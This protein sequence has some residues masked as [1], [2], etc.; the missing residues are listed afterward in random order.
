[1]ARKRRKRNRPPSPNKGLAPANFPEL[2]RRFY[3]TDPHDYFSRRLMGLML[4]LGNTPEFQA[5]IKDEF[6]A[7]DVGVLWRSD[8][9]DEEAEKSR[10]RY[11]TAESEVLLHHISETLLRLYLVH[12]ARSP[13]PWLDIARERDFKKLKGD[14]ADLRDRLQD[15][16][17]RENIEYVFYGGANREAFNPVPEE[18]RWQASLRNIG[19]FLD[20]YAEQ[21]LDS[22]PYNAAKHGMAVV[23]GHSGIELGVNNDPDGP[24]LSKSGP[25]IEYLAIRGDKS[26]PRWAQETKWIDLAASIRLIGMA[27]D[28]LDVLWT[29]GSAHRGGD[30]PEK[31]RLFDYP[32]Y[33][34]MMARSLPE[35]DPATA[36]LAELIT[37]DR[38]SM[39]L[40]Y[41]EE[42]E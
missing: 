8:L 20:R 42:T 39:M 5:A 19:R 38:I 36:P 21:F 33:D 22:A 11:A 34:A 17:E 30:H 13:C 4:W 10:Q 27:R 31:L 40:L 18:E 7:A 14:V 2:N 3:A 32:D 1:M 35:I 16:T 28:L 12:A 15:G 9:S 24:F 41:F 29:V 37:T 26:Q 23:S 25:A 6:K